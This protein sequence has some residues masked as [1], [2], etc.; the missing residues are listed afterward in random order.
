MDLYVKRKR[1]NG[2][3][4]I[5]F[6]PKRKSRKRFEQSRSL[7]QSTTRKCCHR[8]AFIFDQSLFNFGFIYF[9]RSNQFFTV[10]YAY[11]YKLKSMVKMM[12]FEMNI[13]CLMELRSYQKSAKIP[14]NQKNRPFRTDQPIQ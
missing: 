1:S 3:I 5:C 2:E 6:R 8:R 10:F 9:L 11:F 7:F 13:H 14:E 12:H 4:S